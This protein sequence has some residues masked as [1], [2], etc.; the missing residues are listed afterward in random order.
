M[1]VFC[2]AIEM[3]IKHYHMGS[4]MGVFPIFEILSLLELALLLID[5]SIVCIL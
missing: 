1:T 5:I 4:G 2:F 3:R